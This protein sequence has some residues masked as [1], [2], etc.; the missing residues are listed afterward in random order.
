MKITIVNGAK[1]TLDFDIEVILRHFYSLEERPDEQNN[2]ILEK[3]AEIALIDGIGSR[4]IG[5]ID[6]LKRAY[7]IDFRHMPLILNGLLKM[8]EE[9]T[10]ALRRA[11]ELRK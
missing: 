11:E 2:F 6:R 8:A 10:A 5:P 7:L 9:E 4:N 1:R 3:L